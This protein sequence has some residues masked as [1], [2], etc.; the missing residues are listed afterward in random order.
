MISIFSLM[1]P[2][3]L[4]ATAYHVD[5][6]QGNDSSGN[7]SVSAPYRSLGKIMN[8]LKGGDE[9]ILY[10][11]NYGAI[12]YATRTTDIFTDWVE[13]KAAEGALPELDY[14]I[15]HSNDYGFELSGSFDA[16]IRISGM[17]IIGRG[18]D[19]GIAL[20]GS[21]HVVIE[22][23]L[24]EIEGPWTGSEKNIE[25]TGFHLRGGRDIT[26]KNCEITRVGTGI[27]AA[28]HDVKIMYNHIHDITHDGIRV[29]GLNDSLV[30]GNLIHGLDDGVDDSE[31]SWSKHC[32]AIH[33][34]IGGSSVESLLVPNDNVTIRG[35]IIYDIEA[36][37]VQFNNYSPFPD[38]HNANIIFENN[39]FGPVHSVF[40]FNDA[41]IVEGLTIRNNTF[42]YLPGGTSYVNPNNGTQ[43]TLVS[44]NHGLRVTPN[45]TDLEIYNN[46][47]VY[48]GGLPVDNA[49][50][51]ENN[52]ILHTTTEGIDI[53]GPSNVATTEEQ[54]VN[55]A[56]MDGMLLNSSWAI[57]RASKTLDMYGYDIYGTARGVGAEAGAYEYTRAPAIAAEGEWGFD[58]NAGDGSG[59]R[60]DGN[61]LGGAIYSTDRIMGSHSLAF[62]GVDDIVVVPD[63][64]KLRVSGDITLAAYIRPTQLGVEQSIIS[65]GFNEGYRFLITSTNQLKLVLG[66]PES[67]V[68]QVVDASTESS[69]IRAD[70]WQ[71]VAVSVSFSGG[72]GTV[73]FY[74]EGV[75]QS[76]S[77]ELISGIES[78]IDDL[79][80]GG[81]GVSLIEL[82]HG[83]MD[84]V[85][86]FP[87]A[88]TAAEIL[89]LATPVTTPSIDS[90]GDVLMNVG[91]TW[92][93]FASA[94]DVDGELM[95]MSVSGLPSFA[96]FVD[97]G[98]GRADISL[99]PN[100]GDEG[101][102]EIRV[103]V[104][105]GIRSSSESFTLVV[106]E[107][108]AGGYWAFENDLNDGSGWNNH[109]SLVSDA[110]FSLDSV[111]GAAS[112]SLDG[113]GDCAIFSDTSKLRITSDLTL[114]AYI[115][116]SR[117]GFQQNIIAKSYNEGY[118]FRVTSS[119]QLQLIIGLPGGGVVGASPKSALIRAD[120][121]QHIAVTV[122]FSGDL[123]VV[124]FYLDGVLQDSVTV[125]ASGIKEGM[126]PLVV[127]AANASGIEGFSGLIDE[128][129]IYEGAMS[130]LEI[131]GLSMGAWSG[132]TVESGGF[133]NTGLWVG[134]L[135]LYP[136]S[137]WVYAYSINRSIYFPEVPEHAPGGWAYFRK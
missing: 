43:R 102:Y 45:T 91:S 24:I 124:T 119:N 107:P 21:R 20:V 30:E 100:S 33:V 67:G 121:W 64:S 104:S 31:A 32:D 84:D 70:V 120:V 117:L 110:S 44:D 13:F 127:G 53:G 99:A 22:D 51:F 49:D 96:D 35:N 18:V 97:Q 82:Y 118:R 52:V 131:A 6:E 93:V 83:L 23:C 14:V 98:N 132:F 39:I 4:G 9:V 112:L 57:S 123:G 129:R 66:I 133:V 8:L 73:K 65:K 75:L 11:G 54:F 38:V 12:R 55:A 60:H 81:G 105:D 56:A 77:T 76:T 63:E 92:K 68:N 58:D 71:H 125:S 46:I 62:D 137:N 27:A 61:V 25:K 134:W 94:S 136:N 89:D 130:A 50:V 88:L 48:G 10:D 37:A 59:N 122:N 85:S 72:T 7:G 115:K 95:T 86:V 74:I 40:V 3:L 26:L 47:L 15:I 41:D 79:I 90:I 135:F 78:G 69:L 5:A 16:Y 17:H 106:Q 116:P 42:L 109:G 80:I 28:G 87:A 111:V 103:S 2:A 108:N 36:Q 113:V 101:T 128:V 114:A 29:T 1:I 126:G 34:F 19:N